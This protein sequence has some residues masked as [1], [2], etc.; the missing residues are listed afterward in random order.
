MT[1]HRIASLALVAALGCQ[2][3]ADPSADD[4]GTMGDESD[5]LIEA[6]EGALTQTPVALF[7]TGAYASDVIVDG[8]TLVLVEPGQSGWLR[9]LDRCSGAELSSIPVPFL[10]RAILHAGAVVFTGISEGPDPYLVRWDEAAEDF[11]YLTEAPFS[12]LYSHSSGLH[13]AAHDEILRLDEP[14]ES[15][16]LVHTI[17]TPDIPGL[18]ISHIGM[19]EAG[20]YYRVD[21]DCG[22][23]PALARWPIDGADAVGVAGSAGARRLAAVGD[24][25]FINVDQNPDGF[26]SGIDDIVE[27]PAEGGEPLLLFSGTLESGPVQDIAANDEWVC[28]THYATPPRCVSRVDSS[29]LREFV[30]E[31][32]FG[33]I[34]VAGDVVYW[35]VEN[36]G[37]SVLMA[38]A[39]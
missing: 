23:T 26:G 34:A 28:W 33:Q 31:G 17:E 9:R 35:F 24:R 20:F 25:I 2:R 19:S 37:T 27:M 12:R 10:A 22:C 11:V 29:D 38:A 30:G 7:E 1:I 36:E 14:S 4:A 6:C 21:Y 5:D 3:L 16:V 8:D 15:L 39:L 18:S 13:V 32:T